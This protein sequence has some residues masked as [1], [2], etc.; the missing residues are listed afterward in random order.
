MEFRYKPLEIKSSKVSKNKFVVWRPI[1]PVYLLH[2]KKIIGYEAI[3]DS[4]ADFNIFHSEIA[5]ILGVDYK[6]GEKRLLFGMGHQGIKGFECELEIKIQSFDKYKTKIIFSDQIPS[7]SFGVLGNIGFFNKYHVNFKY[8]EKVI[9]VN[10][11]KK[12][13]N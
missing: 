10:S 13:L 9:V 12:A 7:N 3:I 11:S 6:K 5:N 1:V 8:N 2:N 4:G